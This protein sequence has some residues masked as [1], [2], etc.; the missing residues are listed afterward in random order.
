MEPFSTALLAAALFE[1]GKTLVEKGIVDPALEKVLEPLKAWLTRGYDAKKA[2][3]ELRDAFVQVI[4]DSGSSV[5]STDDIAT[6]LKNVGLDRLQAPKNDALRKQV[7]NALIGFTDSKSPPPEDLMIALGWPRSRSNELSGMLFRLRTALA[8]HASWQ[9]LFMYANDLQKQGML[10]GIL[11]KIGRLET[12]LVETAD[13]NAL[14]VVLIE[15]GLSDEQ[16]TQIER[17]YRE[18]LV[19]EFENHTTRGLSPAQL[20]KLIPLPLKDI[21]LEL[22]LI[23]LRTERELEV[24]LEELLQAD[25]T[26]R[27]MH[28][29]RQQQQRVTDLLSQSQKLVIV[30]KPGSGKT[31]SLKFIT[32]MLAHGTMGASRL[33]LD[34]PYVPIY[35]RL[36]QYA[37][38]LKKDSFLALETFLLE[39][40]KRY[41]PG[42]ARQD[43]FLQTALDKGLCMILLD[44][45]DEVGDVGDTLIKGKTLRARVVEEVQRFSNRRCGRECTNRLVVTSRL[46]GYRRGDLPGFTETELGSLAIPDE[47]Q[48]FLLRWFAAYEQ[49][50]HKELTLEDAFRK[51]RERVNALMSDIMRSES[52]QRL[53]MNPLLLTILAMIH[54]MGTRLPNERVRL[55][56]TV[57][58]TMIENWR[59]EQ[60]RHDISIYEVVS[61]SR[62]L[63]IM[64]SLAYWVHMHRPGGSMPDADWRMQIKSLLL[65]GD[66]E[67]SGKV[68][69]L[70]EMFMRHARE[71]V[72]LL[73][74]R[75]PGQIGFFHLTLEEYLAAVDIARK[76]MEERRKRVMEHWKNPRWREVILL[77]AGELMLNSRGDDLVDYINDLRIQDEGHDPELAGQAVLLAGLAVADVGIQNFENK[78]IVRDVRN[79]LELIAKDIDPETR[80]PAVQGRIPALNRAL[81]ADVADE[82]GYTPPDLH[83]F[84]SIPKSRTVNYDF[85]ISRYPVTNAQYERFLRREN[86]ENKNYWVDFPKF[87]EKSRPMNGTWG[88]E[89]WNW[90][91][92]ELQDKDNPIQDGVLLPRHWRDPRFGVSRRNAP[93]VGVSWYEAGA[94]CRWLLENWENLEEGKGGLPKPKTIRLPL[95]TEW[96]SAAGGEDPSERY[97]W[98]RKGATKKIEEIIQRANINESGINRTTPVWMYP[99]GESANGVMDMAGNIWEW[100]ANYQDLER[101]WLGLRGG[102]WGSDVNGARVSFRVDGLPDLRLDLIGFRVVALPS[103]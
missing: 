14:R 41:H 76:G 42:Q 36:A 95:D 79:E 93:V 21:Y 4:K 88:G 69:E 84:I 80:Q 65:S 61:Q 98:D 34:F 75:S 16:L 73:T 82:L 59:I 81:A 89:P 66:E 67:D 32:L 5:E 92:K 23:P 70:V 54:E 39:Y 101:D 18:N 60:T 8:K 13:G 68:D 47:V 77:A 87:D 55:Y 26:K 57:T 2:D 97:P 30:G 37:E 46:E 3:R 9:P 35:V 50:F 99:Q 85:S 27:L 33:R 94:Y 1:A 17:K 24:E 74:E 100:Q 63:P 11:E 86:F 10:S 90:L 78:K 44:G 45:L 71:E 22:G 72:G 6:W 58:R 40:V 56:H 38:E 53:A 25:H 7:A 51:A 83:V 31:V 15:R 29:L 103:G 62:I 64:A 91:Q 49:E 96:T 102:S 12:V 52:V 19:F 48:E 43:E 20:P 28:E